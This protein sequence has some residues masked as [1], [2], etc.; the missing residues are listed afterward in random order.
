MEFIKPGPSS[1]K[2]FKTN[3]APF[4]SKA[5]LTYRQSKNLMHV[6]E[7]LKVP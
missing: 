3:N 5:N 1:V 2:P 6:S 4:A 7:T